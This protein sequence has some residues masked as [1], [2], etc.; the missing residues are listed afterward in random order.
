MAKIYRY[1]PA[2]FSG[3]K[4]ETVEF[5]TLEELL[6]IDFV[7]GFSKTRDGT[8]DPE[9]FK[10]SYSQYPELRSHKDD[11]FTLMA[12]YKD[13]REWFVIGNVVDS[14]PPDGLPKWIPK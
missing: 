7:K 9:F 8:P 3:F 10:Y 13:G 2:F 12:E 11:E 14:I 4:S 5:N 6:N 1:R